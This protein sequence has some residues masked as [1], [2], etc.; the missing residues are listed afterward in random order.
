[1]IELHAAHGYLLHEFLSPLTNV[2]TD[3]YGGD[4]AG[5]VA[6]AARDRRRGPRRASPTRMP[7]F[8]R[9]SATDWVDGGL[10]VDDVAAVTRRAR[11]RSV[12]T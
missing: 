12:S 8:V 7:L 1:M 5:R 2:R 4:L 3:G 11:P 9:V 10:T 6:P